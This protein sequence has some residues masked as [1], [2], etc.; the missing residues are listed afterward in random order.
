M[1]ALEGAATWSVSGETAEL[2]SEE[3]T[4][5]VTLASIRPMP[6]GG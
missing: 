4:I 5:Q 6:L 3:D 1:R 2:R